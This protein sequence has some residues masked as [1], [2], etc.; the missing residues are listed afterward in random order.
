[1]DR[2]WE[3]PHSLSV[4]I[5]S[6][7]ERSYQRVQAL[8]YQGREFKDDDFLLNLLRDLHVIP[9]DKVT[10]KR[11]PPHEALTLKI[12]L[13][14]AEAWSLTKSRKFEDHWKKEDKNWATKFTSEDEPRSELDFAEQSIHQTLVTS[15][16]RFLKKHNR[17]QLLLDVVK[18]PSFSG[19]VHKWGGPGFL[20]SENRG[21]FYAG[22]AEDPHLLFKNNLRRELPKLLLKVQALMRL[23]FPLDDTAKSPPFRMGTIIVGFELGGMSPESLKAEGGVPEELMRQLILLFEILHTEIPEKYVLYRKDRESHKP[24]RLIAEIEKDE[25]HAAVNLL[26][27]EIAALAERKGLPGWKLPTDADSSQG[28]NFLIAF[29]E[30]DQYLS[31]HLRYCLTDLNYEAMRDSLNPPDRWLDKKRY[32]RL[33]EVMTKLFSRTH[34]AREAEELACEYVTQCERAVKDVVGASQKP[35]EVA[36]K[37]YRLIESNTYPL[38]L[39][40]GYHVMSLGYPEIVNDWLSD[41]RARA[42]EQYP[43]I[44]LAWEHM[45]VSGEIYY[46]PIAD[47]NIRFGICGVNAELLD[48]GGGFELQRLIDDSALRFRN[49]ICNKLIRKLQQA[50]SQARLDGTSGV[51]LWEEALRHFRQFT[52][53]YLTHQGDY[54]TKLVSDDDMAAIDAAL[55]RAGASWEWGETK[56]WMLVKEGINGRVAAELRRVQSRLPQ[57]YLDEYL[58]QKPKGLRRACLFKIK[59]QDESKL[60]LLTL[61][62]SPHNLQHATELIHRFTSACDTVLDTDWWDARREAMLREIG[63]EFVYLLPL[64]RTCLPKGGGRNREVGLLTEV[65]ENEVAYYN[66]TYAD[67]THGAR[68]TVLQ[69][70]AL[71]SAIHR[72]INQGVTKTKGGLEGSL[73]S[74]KAENLLRIKKGINQLRRST[75]Y[76]RFKDEE[77]D[78]SRSS[79]LLL[80]WEISVNLCKH[81]KSWVEFSVDDAEGG[82]LTIT[83]KSDRDPSSDGHK[84]RRG[85]DHIRNVAEVAGVKFGSGL[86]PDDKMVYRSTLTF[87]KGAHFR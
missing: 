5:R 55:A 80:L 11:P 79:A 65:L 1:M 14:Y 29:R 24:S 45:A 39:T 12:P 68:I 33:R 13:I 22:T 36:K 69:F 28:Y 6:N 30:L 87:R 82:A 17:S 16:N 41:T 42:F 71:L 64:L 21:A 35:D 27:L 62:P 60:S 72:L 54:F 57:D 67:I 40:P 49:I 58:A 15:V 4:Y 10:L 48:R 59:L 74:V 50:L 31:G 44:L 84:G 8:R 9:L 85:I 51:T 83:I 32:R 73:G 61:V 37:L 70:F 81:A 18:R 26:H 19:D 56:R 7:L 34:G 78:V 63:H 76:G 3:A 86:H 66:K 47:G 20:H 53:Y 25:L 75:Q 2:D 38:H 43:H 23:T 46:S 77:L 52:Y